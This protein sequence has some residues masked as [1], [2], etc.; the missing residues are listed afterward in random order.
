MAYIETKDL[1]MNENI[2]EFAKEAGII[3]V[4]ETTV[5]PTIVKFAELI[6]LECFESKQEVASKLRSLISHFADLTS[7]EQALNQINPEADAT[8]NEIL[9]LINLLTNVEK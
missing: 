4:S 3:G 6:V 9:E 2:I 1:K 8:W 7:Q 5:A